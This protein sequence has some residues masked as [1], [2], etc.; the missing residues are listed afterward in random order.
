[1]P[2]TI[3]DSRILIKTSSVTTEV[4]TVAPSNDHTDGTWSVVDVYSGEMFLNT[5]D[6]KIWFRA[7]SSI[8]E[9]ATK[10]SNQKNV[11]CYNVTSGT[12]IGRAHV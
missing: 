10:I 7:A 11:E 12:E 4:P 1:M 3:Q 2:L 6:K 5:A 9:V 8:V